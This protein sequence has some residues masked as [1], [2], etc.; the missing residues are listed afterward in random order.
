MGLEGEAFAALMEENRRKYEDKWE[1]RLPRPKAAAE[2]ARALAAKARDA[3]SAS[4]IAE[5]L[6]LLRDAIARDP[7]CADHYNDLGAVL[8]QVGRHEQAHAFFLQALE[9]D[10]AHE[11]ARAN[12][13][14]TAQ[15]LHPPEP[16][17]V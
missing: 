1:V 15:S 2:Q 11:A 16:P 13:T 12:A 4:D 10:P 14:A 9:R 3:A 7:G 5:A 8:W 17:T 6:R